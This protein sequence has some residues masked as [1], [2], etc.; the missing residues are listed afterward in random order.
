VPRRADLR[1]GDLVFFANTYRDGIS[2]VGVYVGHGKFVHAGDEVEVDSFRTRYW[3][4][5]FRAGVRP[6]KLRATS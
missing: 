3:R 2:H 6:R 1:R 5:H 4:R